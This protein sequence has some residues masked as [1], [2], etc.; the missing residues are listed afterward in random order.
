MMSL[1]ELKKKTDLID[2]INWDMTPEEAVRLYL[3]WATTGR[4]ATGM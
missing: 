3:E 2:E 4:G 1:E